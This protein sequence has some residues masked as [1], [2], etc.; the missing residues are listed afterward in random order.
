MR[1]RIVN[2]IVILIFLFIAL[3]I[4][5]LEVIQGKK[6]RILSNQNCI[7]LIPQ[8]GS[9]GR[10]LD[11]QGNV[12]VD[13]NLS[14]NVM[15]SSYGNNEI[16][17]TLLGA[18]RVLNVNLKD[19]Q[20]AFRNRYIAS[21]MPTT[22][23]KNIDVKKA[24]ALEELKPD[25]D[26]I[27]IHLYPL[28]SYPYGKLACHVL[29]Y[30]NEIDLWRLT[31]LANYGYKTKDIVGFGGV[32]EK[33]DYLLRQE[34]G[35]LSVEVDHRGRLVSVLGF[36][37]PRNGK[38]I[39]LT[40]DLK[41]QKIVEENLRGRNGS[42]IL[43]D[44]FSGEIIA[45]ANNPNFNPSV[46]VKKSDSSILNL[47]ADSDAPFINRAIT[48]VYPAGSIFKLVVATAALETGKINLSTTFSCPGS[49]YIGK[50]EFSCWDTHNLQNLTSA[51]AN[52]CNVFFYRT[53][54]LTGAQTIYDYAVK[55]GFSHP[56]AIDLPYEAGGFVPS[57]LLRKI[58]KFKNWFDGD[59]ANLA[60]GQGELLVTPI[61]IIRMMAV[62]ANKGT[63]VTPYIVK[64]IDGQEVANLKRRAVK[65]S[66]KESTINY[67]RQGL[68]SVVADPK[69]TANALSSLP[70][71]V[72]G[73][74]GTAQVHQGQPHGW[75][76]GFFPYQAPKF[77]I[78]VFLEHG[79]SGHAA[80]IVAKQIIES[81]IKEGL[82]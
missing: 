68:R 50:Q 6:F 45:M 67:I 14:Y 47:F 35:G 55:L 64:A 54:L 48:G 78:C 43:M 65:L 32:E 63:L 59:T 72:A 61:Q 60:I 46:F 44:P 10:I 15:V 31:K 11:R 51:I 30:L 9:R 19:L 81:M 8:E 27:M 3:N 18:A 12:I 36:R 76:A 39:Q 23:A 25:L 34:A 52:S 70:V 16:D 74:T 37:P 73:K 2:W 62:F 49:M 57:P 33:Y 56:T 21:F 28:R 80:S 53:G 26:N 66:V 17:K 38:D 42:A 29:G 7:R 5:N 22:I 69:G 77:V 58:Y 71:S 13:N 20:S 4:L 40:I 75:F 24:I 82:I 1:I 79:G 41:I